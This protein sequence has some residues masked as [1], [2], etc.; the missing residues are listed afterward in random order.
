VISSSRV[1]AASSES[2][3]ADTAGEAGPAKSTAASIAISLQ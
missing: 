1:A 2:I 3:I